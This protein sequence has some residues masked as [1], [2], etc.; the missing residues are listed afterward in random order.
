MDDVDSLFDDTPSPHS[1]VEGSRRTA[2]PI[3]GLYFDPALRLPPELAEDAMWTCIRMYFQKSA[4]DQVM[5]FERASSPGRGLPRVL[6]ALLATL[7][8]LLRP[9]LPPEKHTLLFPSEPTGC[10]RQAILNLYWPGGGIIPHVDLLDRYGDGII[11]RVDSGPHGE[12]QQHGLY[13]PPGSVIVLT[14]EA[15]YGWTHGIEERMEDEVECEDKPGTAGLLPRDIRLSITFR[16]LLPGA[17]VVGGPILQT[18]Q[19]NRA[20]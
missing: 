10:A 14:E 17:D 19:D 6:T 1:A 8:D 15:R 5:L 4:V 2:P 7:A 13:L 16:W 18:V 12:G 9:L 3:P 20:H 11:G